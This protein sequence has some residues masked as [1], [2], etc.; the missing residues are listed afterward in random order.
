MM[1][2]GDGPGT[3]AA[4]TQWKTLH[5]QTKDLSPWMTEEVRIDH[6]RASKLVDSTTG[7]ASVG[8][9]EETR[10]KSCKRQWRKFAVAA[11]VLGFVS[12]L[13]DSRE[14]QLETITL[15]TYPATLLVS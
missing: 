9:D 3:D 13:E 6:I 15:L 10:V 14:L 4:W 12:S 8:L 1:L 2:D 11:A 5:H 7:L